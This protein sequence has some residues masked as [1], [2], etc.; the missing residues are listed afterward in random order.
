[1]VLGR[2]SRWTR[3]RDVT[4]TK[5][6]VALLAL[7]LLV[8]GTWLV[9]RQVGSR[10]V[11]SQMAP[12]DACGGK[13]FPL[14]ALADNSCGIGP[15]LVPDRGVWWGATANPL[16]GESWAESLHNLEGEVGRSFDIAHY[17]HS[18]PD[19]FPT[20]SEI[21][22]AHEPGHHRILLLNWKPEMGRT[23]AQV[24]AGDPVADAAIDREADHLKTTFTEPFFLAIHHE[25]EDEVQSEPGSGMTAQDYAAMFRH[26]VERLRA[27]GVHN[28]VT[29]LDYHGSVHWGSQP[30]FDDLYPGDDVVDWLAEDPFI[31]DAH[32]W[33]GSFARALNRTDKS[34]PGWPGFYKWAHRRHPDKPIML[35]EWGVDQAL[36]S[37]AKAAV[38]SGVPAALIRFPQVKALVYWNADAVHP[39]GTTRVDSS[40]LALRA[41]QIVGA[42]RAVH[43]P[44]ATFDR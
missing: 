27:D 2:R 35:A 19:L 14:R 10:D 42:S 25:P 31:L 40:P 8:G 33:D 29:V 32:G 20:P 18:S 38:I 44:T 43:Q 11:G 6:L 30:W 4:G 23:W 21:E 26:V 28:A 17:Y 24:A 13:T 16:K 39:V 12:S 7:T 37:E 9:S 1:M 5:V 36:G 34:Q 41:F 15:R 3:R 22:A